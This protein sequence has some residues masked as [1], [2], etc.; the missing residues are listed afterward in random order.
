MIAAWLVVIEYKLHTGGAYLIA[1]AISPIKHESLAA[2]SR[3]FCRSSV[4]LILP[5]LLR[6]A[7]VA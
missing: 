6:L 7:E 2:R 3:M 1:C 4:D 5:V